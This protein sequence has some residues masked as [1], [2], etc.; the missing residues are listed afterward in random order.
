MLT[1][2]PAAFGRTATL[3]A[4]ASWLHPPSASPPVRSGTHHRRRKA[5]RATTESSSRTGPLPA[6]LP[7]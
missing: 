3:R 1:R 4:H 5:G 6:T 7:D 2:R